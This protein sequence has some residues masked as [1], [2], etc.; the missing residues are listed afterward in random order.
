MRPEDASTDPKVILRPVQESDVP[1]FA[2]IHLDAW[3][4]AY[5]GLLPDELLDARTLEGQTQKWH[6]SLAPMIAAGNDMAGGERGADGEATPE[7]PAQTSTP[8]NA[9]GEPWDECFVAEADGE[10]VGW[11]IVGRAREE[12][13]QHMGELKGIYVAPEHFGQGAGSALIELGER[14]IAA[15]GHESAYLWVLAGNERA[16]RFYQSHGWQA[17]SDYAS[18]IVS[19]D[20]HAATEERYTKKLAF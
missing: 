11:I 18:K 20:G 16:I 12:N 5:R 9:S 14:T 8:D 1:Q 2:R 17:P 6:R 19:I 13:Y 15:H 3:A 7:A 10:L 4:E